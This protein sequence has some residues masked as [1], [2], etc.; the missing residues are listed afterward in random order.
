MLRLIN[1]ALSEAS[2]SYLAARQ[3]DIDGRGTFANRASR[4]DTLWDGKTGPNAGERAFDEVK[5]TLIQMCVG[6]EICNYCEQSEA[7]DIE[8]I[9]PKSLFPQSTFVWDNYLLACK[10]CNTTH[11]LDAIYIFNPAHSVNTQWVKRG[12]EPPTTDYAF[13]Q[14]RLEDPMDWMELSLMDFQFYARP[15]HAPGT[16]GFQKVERTLEILALNNRPTLVN[17]RRAAFGHF[18]RLLGEYV[19]VK[20]ATTHQALERAVNG[21]PEV[22]PA[23]PFR[24]EQ[25]RIL[26][27]IQQSIL[28]GEHPTV[29]REM[30]R[31]RQRLAP[32]VQQLFAQAPEALT[33]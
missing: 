22:N 31:Q 11:K 10:K 32:L 9:L 28:T 13:I 27:A 16:R 18:K 21:D 24:D 1:K 2:S 6:V 7:S 30:V 5:N 8:H 33:W 20:N 12:T 26:N 25:T 17:Y 14:P 29:W 3:S 4:A 23:L 19:A 15:P